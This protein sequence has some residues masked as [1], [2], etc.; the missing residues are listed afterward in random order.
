M[1]DIMRKTAET[2]ETV[3]M[4]K[5]GHSSSRLLGRVGEEELSQSI[6]ELSRVWVL[7]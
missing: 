6:Q 1:M 3:F 7:L 5:S 2:E 4:P